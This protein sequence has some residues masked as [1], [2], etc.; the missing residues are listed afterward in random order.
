M[1]GIISPVVIL[2][3]P[4]SLIHSGE[5][6]FLLTKSG[7][8]CDDIGK[9][10]LG[11]EDEC[12]QAAKELDGTFKGEWYTTIRPKGCF[13]KYKNVYWNKHSTGFGNKFSKAICRRSSKCILLI[14]IVRYVLVKCSW[15]DLLKCLIYL[16]YN[17]RTG[18]WWNV[19]FMGWVVV[20]FKDMCRRG[21]AKV[22]Y[23]YKSKT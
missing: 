18:C 3:N 11:T 2:I 7:K 10:L 1:L 8:T 14:C 6:Q 22:S 23:M 21:N 9:G 17:R 16:F 12:K 15:K 5:K 13:W 20:M 4:K 19:V